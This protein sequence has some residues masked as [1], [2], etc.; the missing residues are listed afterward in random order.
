MR[1][2]LIRHGEP[3]VAVAIGLPDLAAR[4]S[5][6][7]VLKKAVEAMARRGAEAHA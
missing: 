2:H 7:F 6:G 4:R 5:W 3:A 1:L